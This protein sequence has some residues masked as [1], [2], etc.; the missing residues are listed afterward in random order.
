MS[1]LLRPGRPLEG[2]RRRWAARPPRRCSAA[3]DRPTPPTCQDVTVPLDNATGKHRGFGFVEYDDPADAAAAVDNLHNAELYGRTL[4]VNYAQ[5]ARIKGGDKGVAHQARG[6]GGGGWWDALEGWGGGGLAHL[7]TARGR[8]L[9]CHPPTPPPPSR[10]LQAVWADAD[11]WY[12]RAAA[13]A[14]LEK[15]GGEGTN[16]GGSGGGGTGAGAPVAA[17]DPM[18][19][20]EAEAGG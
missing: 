5:P 8:S 13:E 1:G 16:G 3:R 15:L 17:D 9:A 19:R 7:R 6:R 20:A 14:E 18:A 11:D 10:P 2:G 12:D 4:R